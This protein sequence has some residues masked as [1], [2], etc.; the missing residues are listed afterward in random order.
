MAGLTFESVNK[1]IEALDLEQLEMNLNPKLRKQPLSVPSQ[2]CMI[3]GK[4][5]GIVRFMVRLPLPK[6]WK[7]ALQ[8]L[9]KTLDMLCPS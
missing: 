8:L 3:W 6:K 7:Q 4:V 9:I 5:G 1:Q 2:I